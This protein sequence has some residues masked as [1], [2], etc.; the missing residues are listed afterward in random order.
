MCLLSSQAW[1][2]WVGLKDGGR[3]AG[4]HIKEGHLVRTHWAKRG[5]AYHCPEE[6]A[7]Q[8]PLGSSLKSISPDPS[9]CDWW[10]GPGKAKTVLVT[11]QE[12]EVGPTEPSASPPPAHLTAYVTRP[13][14]QSLVTVTSANLLKW[15]PCLGHS[16]ALVQR[17]KSFLSGKTF[18]QGNVIFMWEMGSTVRTPCTFCVGEDRLAP[19]FFNG[20]SFPVGMGT[21]WAESKKGLFWMLGLT[22]QGWWTITRGPCLRDAR[23]YNWIFIGTHLTHSSVYCLWLLSL[24]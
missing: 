9:A 10:E 24:E 12:L 4:L 20:M 3:K 21:H 2:E 23:L 17:K 5:A 15:T 13:G 19:M 16:F 7:P 14:N 22:V 8:V 18:W 11:V 1:V 6:V